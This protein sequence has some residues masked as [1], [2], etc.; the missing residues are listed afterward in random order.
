MVFVSRTQIRASAGSGKTYRITMDFLDFLSG[1]G[2]TGTSACA[3]SSNAPAGTGRYA[4]QE[5]LAVTFTNSAAAEMRQRVLCTLKRVAMGQQEKDGIDQKAALHWISVILERFSAL[6]IRT[7]DS[8]LHTVVRLSALQLRLPPDFEPV[9]STDEALTPLLDTLLSSAKD[10]PALESLLEKACEDVVFHS[11]FKGFQ[12]GEAVREQVLALVL[13]LFLDGDTDELL[14]TA[15]LTQRYEALT[16]A[17]IASGKRMNRHIVDERL[18]ANSHFIKAVRAC[19]ELGLRDKAPGSTMLRKEC[20]NDCLN[21]ASKG[22]ASLAAELTFVELATTVGQLERQGALLRAGLRLSPFV[23]LATLLARALP[24]HLAAEGRVPQALIPTLAAQALAEGGGVSESFCRMGTA[25]THILIDEFQDTSR[26]QWAAIQ[27]L[28]LEALSRGGSLTWVGDVKQAIYGWRDGD[29]TL[30]DEVVKDAALMRVCPPV[31]CDTLPYNRRSLPEVVQHNN[32]VFGRLA[33]PDYARRALAALLPADT[34]PDIFT[35]TTD[36]LSRAFAG[37]EQIPLSEKEGGYV[38]MDALIA[39]VQDELNELVRVHFTA[40]MEELLCR[41]SAS[42]LAVLVRSNYQVSL[43]AQW[44][45][46]MGVKVL[47]ESSF[48][49]GEHPLVKELLALLAFLDSPEDDAAF[50]SLILGTQLFLPASGLPEAAIHEWL[51]AAT[52]KRQRPPLYTQFR[53]AFPGQWAAWLQPFYTGAGLLTA[54][55]TVREA[56]NRFCVSTR[57]PGQD[58]FARRFL[59]V[60]YT[61]E[62]DGHASLADFLEYWKQHGDKEKAPMPAGL[63]AVQVMTVH[64]SKG[65]QFPV[66]ICP[67][68]DLAPDAGRHPLRVWLED[69]S[70]ALLARPAKG[71]DIWY[72]TLAD[73]AREGLHRLYVAW[74]RAEEELYIV[75]SSTKRSTHAAH[76]LGELLDADFLDSPSPLEWGVPRHTRQPASVLVSEPAAELPIA[77][78]QP[79]VPLAPADT[80]GEA[81]RPLNWMPGLR[82]F[83][84]PLAELAYTPK[85]RGVF[86]HHCLERLRISGNPTADAEL[87]VSR[88]LAEFPIT[89]AE[90]ELARE[91]L[92]ERLAWYAAQPEAAHWMRHGTP[93]Q[94]M[95]DAQGRILRADLLVDDG[96]TVTVVDYKTGAPHTAHMVQVQTYMTLLREAQPLPVQGRLV[97]MDSDVIQE[98]L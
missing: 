50:L 25:L 81:W 22:V 45:L 44:L 18:N 9:F 66:V 82:I 61:A 49:L 68:Q 4:W 84:S 34:P 8:L 40:L 47:T 91:D 38:R 89:L 96:E 15:E 73:S 23:A 83:R 29:A 32:T 86:V 16:R 52:T 2:G 74:T 90:P 70:G 53:S 26:D 54:Y 7:I 60:L 55:D 20:L 28:A 62:N 6:N 97:Y 41:R 46:D 95:L 88:G 35:E 24:D 33:D 59:E 93:E 75:V 5:I 39:D 94:P 79:I 14:E 69:G 21:K 56:L 98:V 65:R 48:L 77:P 42:E 76:V 78:L 3:L 85:R 13:P 67:W 92:V 11:D 36:L 17:V 63:D 30:F 19:V 10:M 43:V 72:T 64:K 57:L 87:A 12:A 1:A 31:I 27:P 37:G 71:L 51:V 58:V 80:G